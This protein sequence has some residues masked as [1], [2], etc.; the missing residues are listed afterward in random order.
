MKQMQP[1]KRTDFL[2]IKNTRFRH[3]AIEKSHRV[4]LT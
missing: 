4:D 3:A 1:M 2:V